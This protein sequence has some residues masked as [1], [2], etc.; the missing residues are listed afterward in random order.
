MQNQAAPPIAVPAGT[1]QR[2][3]TK[4]AGKNSNPRTQRVQRIAASNFGNPFWTGFLLPRRS[5]RRV[6]RLACANLTDICIPLEIT[7]PTR[8]Q[9]PRMLLWPEIHWWG[10]RGIEG[11]D[12]LARYQGKAPM[13]NH[14]LF[15]RPV[16]R[17]ML[18]GLRTEQG[19]A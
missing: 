14:T 8:S 4:A 6:R 13:G 16:G 12:V 7:K 15:A 17:A 10:T 19:P 5:G 2:D 1:N 18:P 11:V 3:P 9:Q